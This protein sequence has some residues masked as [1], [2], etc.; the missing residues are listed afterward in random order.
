MKRRHLMAV[1]ALAATSAPFL[2]ACA[3]G[4]DD[5]AKGKVGISMPTKTSERWIAD[6]ENLEKQFEDAG[7]DTILNF[8]EDKVDRQISQIENMIAQGVNTL[9]IAAKDGSTLSGVLATAKQ[10]DIVVISYDRLIRDTKDVDYYVTF[11]N[12]QVGQLQGGYIVDALDLDNETGPFNIEL[13]AGSLDDNNAFYF[14]D[15][16]I[17][18]LQPYID[19]GKLVVRSE[20]VD[21]EQTATDSWLA[22]NAQ[23]RMD[24]LLATFYTDDK[25]HA[26]LSPFD[27]I[28]QG[29]I[30]SLES[31]GYS[32]DDLPVIT[33]QDAEETSIQYIIDGRQTATVF[34]DTRALASQAFDM[35]TSVLDEEEVE[36][37]DTETYDNGAKVVPS[38]LLEPVS[39]D[40]SNWKEVLIEE[41]GYYAEGTFEGE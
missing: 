9:I 26:I 8:A 39:V 25:V 20:Q 19:D 21:I 22:E 23:D 40:A 29:I 10:E 12:Y 41:S 15:G 34:K 37:N 5:S 6:G 2:T 7:F 32:T 38:F 13:F 16:A 3:T 27:G 1:G 4:G 14:W 31:S 18:A 11:D 36:V 17:D 35:T 30:A 33:G 28:S 24:D